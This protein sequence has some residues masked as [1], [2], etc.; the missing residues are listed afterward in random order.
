M[1]IY[2]LV[3]RQIESSKKLIQGLNIKIEE[4]QNTLKYSN[5][6]DQYEIIQ[7]G[8]TFISNNYQHSHRLT[9][10]KNLIIYIKVRYFFLNWSIGLV[11]Q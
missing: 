10:Q 4:L 5:T 2:N 9:L 11:H 6:L 7:E 1:Y 8:L 3:K